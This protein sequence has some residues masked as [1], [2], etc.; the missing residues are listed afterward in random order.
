MLWK[1]GHHGMTLVQHRVC[2]RPLGYIMMLSMD[3]SVS[4]EF[5]QI[6]Y[7]GHPKSLISMSADQ[8]VRA[9]TRRLST[10]RK[11]RLGPVGSAVM[12]TQRWTSLLLKS[13][14]LWGLI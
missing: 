9:L 1:C 2:L 6:A 12:S 11:L 14:I 7:D 3:D 8:S 5:F 13:Q 10:G 4:L